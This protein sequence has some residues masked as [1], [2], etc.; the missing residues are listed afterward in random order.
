M[1]EARIPTTIMISKENTARMNIW[2]KA[3]YRISAIPNKYTETGKY[4]KIYMEAKIPR[5]D[6]ANLIKRTN[7]IFSQIVLGSYSNKNRMELRP[8]RCIA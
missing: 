7:A 4:F 5:I 2:S 6:K 8:R 3:A 1:V